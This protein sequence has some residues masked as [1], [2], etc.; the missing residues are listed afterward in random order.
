MAKKKRSDGNYS[1]NFTYDG[2]RY[3]VYAKKQ[4]DLPD[5]KAEKIR[6]IEEKKAWVEKHGGTFQNPTLS[7]YYDRFTDRR[8][9]EVKE[10]SIRVQRF[11]FDL[12]AAVE[13]NG[14]RF[15]DY[16]V[17]EITR[18]DVFELRERLL[19]SGKKPNNINQCIGH[20]SY[21]LK[22]AVLDDIIDRNPVKGIKP[23]PEQSEVNETTHRALTVSE[24]MSFFKAASDCYYSNA[25]RFMINTGVRAGEMGALY[26]T[27]IDYKK[28]VI[29]IRRT[30]TRD[31]AGGF[32]IGETTKTPAGCRDI[33]LTQQV[34]EIIR[35]QMEQNEMIFGSDA[36]LIFRSPEN[37]PVT[38][39]LLNK[40]IRKMC[41]RAGVAPFTSHA[42]RNTFATRF[43]EQRPQDF[44]ILSEIMGHG[45]ISI[46]LNL[47]TH[48]MEENK[49]AA[50][51]GISIVM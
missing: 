2:K 15:G 18:P 21:V 13:I 46:T 7:G 37:A 4:S 34:V 14:R 42:F 28:R 30:I 31:E 5:K 19:K 35:E 6:Q 48:V 51:N 3:C 50:M 39:A 24:T 47:Y 27:D 12:M 8:R 16:K 9:N 17:R 49:V 43:M 11:Q 23:M 10:N 36:G 22:S 38:H 25:F 41:K 45:D 32:E 33:P 20:L 40:A 1:L 44:K 26:P 29:H